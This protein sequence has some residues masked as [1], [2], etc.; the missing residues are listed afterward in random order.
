M[1]AEKKKPKKKKKQA[2]SP[3]C[4]LDCFN[5]KFPDCIN[6]NPPSIEMPDYWPEE[7]KVLKREN[8]RARYMQRKKDGICT[9]CGI[10]KATN[11]LLCAEC[12]A[13]RHKRKK[14]EI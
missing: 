14:E 11:G 12:Y 5:C 9:I 2:K 3:V 13:K 10:R 8:Q 7:K 1:T 6:N 4:D